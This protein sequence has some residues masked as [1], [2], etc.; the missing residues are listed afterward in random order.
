MMM[1]DF[2]IGNSDRHQSNWALLLKPS[3][4][5]DG[6]AIRIRWCPLYDN[7]S[8]LCCYVNS[9][10]LPLL[11]G[12][13]RMRFAAFVDSKSKSLIRIDGSKNTLPSHRE[14]VKYLLENFSV[15]KEIANNILKNLTAE[16]ISLL[17][18]E[19]PSEI[20]FEK[21]QQLIHNYLSEKLH[22]LEKLIKEVEDNDRE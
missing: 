16:K 8:S 18:K 20:L 6:I 1:F 15:A 17:L 4:E 11:L 7:G 9:V 19:Y 5:D 21:K 10:N 2:L 14:V 12:N 13:D 22:I 3:I